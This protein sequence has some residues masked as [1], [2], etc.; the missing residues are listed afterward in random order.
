MNLIYHL[1]QMHSSS[2]I[3]II[4]M[5]T[6]LQLSSIGLNGE[7]LN[8][9]CKGF[10]EVKSENRKIACACVLCGGWLKFIN[11]YATIFI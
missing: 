2:H 9:F 8:E 3:F 7:W 4:D 10:N 6:S 11:N 1:T 5:L